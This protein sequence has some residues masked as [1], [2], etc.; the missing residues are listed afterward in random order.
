MHASSWSNGL[1]TAPSN[2]VLEGSGSS[3]APEPF[4]EASGALGK[5]DR[6]QDFLGGGQACQVLAEPRRKLD[7]H[8]P[9]QIGPAKIAVHQ[10]RSLTRRSH[11]KCQRARDGRFPLL[12][13]GAGYKHYGGR[14]FWVK[15][16]DVPSQYPEGLKI[17]AINV[18]GTIRGIGH[19]T[20]ALL[21]HVS[22]H[23]KLE[24]GL[25]VTRFPQ[26]AIHRVSYESR[27]HPQQQPEEQPDDGLPSLVR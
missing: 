10:Q 16:L 22:D 2:P 1:R 11:D 21:A 19:M 17:E 6:P 15:E 18:P 4:S 5:E 14:P 20:E 23:R 8:S 27:D 3:G 26:P 13:H 9:R 12:G 7:A 24:G 25:E